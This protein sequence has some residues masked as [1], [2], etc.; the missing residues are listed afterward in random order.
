MGHVLRH[1]CAAFAS[2]CPWCGDDID[3]GDAIV[4]AE[5]DWIHSE[6][7]VEAGYEVD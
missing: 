2:K 3:E 1:V 6:C 5:G 4:C 7:G